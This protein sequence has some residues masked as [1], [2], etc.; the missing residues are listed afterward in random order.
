MEYVL[1]ICFLYHI[2]SALLSFLS[3]PF[4]PLLSLPTFTNVTNNE[5]NDIAW[6]DYRNKD[7]L[8]VIKKQPKNKKTEGNSI[9]FGIGFIKLKH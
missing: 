9:L 1:Q 4:S 2:I 8:W 7:S 6:F 3:P 5:A